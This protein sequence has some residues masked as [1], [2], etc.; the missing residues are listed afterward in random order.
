MTDTDDEL[1]YL[2]G[3]RDGMLEAARLLLAAPTLTHGSRRCDLPGGVRRVHDRATSADGDPQHVW[4]TY[5]LR[6]FV[7]SH[8]LDQLEALGFPHPDE[9]TP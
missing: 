7:T 9:V 3:F 1:H 6:D 5:A 8:M 2:N 4:N